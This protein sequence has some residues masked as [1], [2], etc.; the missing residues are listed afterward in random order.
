MALVELM[1]NGNDLP[2]RISKCHLLLMQQIEVNI[3]S[4]AGS[5]SFI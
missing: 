2:A 4:V 1:Y 3:K 5:G